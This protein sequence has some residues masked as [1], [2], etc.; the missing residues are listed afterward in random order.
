MDLSSRKLKREG[1]EKANHSGKEISFFR[2]I[3][4]PRPGSQ[5]ASICL[6]HLTTEADTYDCETVIQHS[7]AVKTKNNIYIYIVG[8]VYVT[9]TKLEKCTLSVYVYCRKKTKKSLAHDKHRK[10]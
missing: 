2:Y 1:Q 6:Y 4:S 8:T 3:I 5:E 10:I 9:R 7:T